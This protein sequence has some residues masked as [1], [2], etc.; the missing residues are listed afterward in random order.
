MIHSIDGGFYDGLRVLITGDTGFKGSWLSEWLMSLGSDLLGVSLPPEDV[1]SMYGVLP[2]A[3][4][5]HVDADIRDE[6]SM[7]RLVGAF[8]PDVIFHLAAQALVRESYV[9][10]VDTVST[11]VLGTA[12]VLEAARRSSV[13]RPCS[14]VVVTSD[15]C[16]ANDGSGVRFEESHPMGGH[17]VYSASK[18]AA[19]LV[20]A[21]WRSSF[22]VGGSAADFRVATARA[23]NVLGGGDWA[24]DRLVPDM[25][26][27][28][29]NGE[30]IL[31]RN[32]LATRPWQHVLEPL[33]GYLLL[34][35]RLATVGDVQEGWN[36]GPDAGGVRSVGEVCDAVV[37][38]WGSGEWTT[39]AEEDALYEA[40]TLELSNDK[41][42]DRLGWR[43]VWSFDE[44]I[45]RTVEWYRSGDDVNYSEKAMQELTRT[46]I[47][48]YAA[49]AKSNGGSQSMIPK[50]RPSDRSREIE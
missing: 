43:P 29:A 42:R 30:P 12:V 26:R 13:Q 16:Y 5:E 10:P 40:P 36:F 1:R 28:L 3:R 46:Q 33:S 8:S 11:N 17:D 31:V 37:R 34:G 6:D 24:I 2:A 45:S 7:V 32:P 38:H 41:S 47:S 44:T 39:V 18:G 35:M 49:A 27:A 22:T 23:G 14:I 20:A 15:K 25:H 4:Y 21:S 19:E 9:S 50:D 48:E